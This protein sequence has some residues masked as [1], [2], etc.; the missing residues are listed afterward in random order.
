M[1]GAHVVNVGIPHCA[2]NLPGWRDGPRTRE[3]VEVRAIVIEEKRKEL[4]ET[5]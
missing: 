1:V 3:S 4:S 2:F 5:N